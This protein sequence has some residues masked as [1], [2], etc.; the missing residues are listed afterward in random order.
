MGRAQN[1]KGDA[2]EL[3]VRA[4]AEPA[5]DQIGSSLDA[6]YE[7]AADS[8]P[9][10]LML[11]DEGLVP[12]SQRISRDNWVLFIRQMF[13]FFPFCGSFENYIFTIK[14]VFG[15]DAFIW[16]DVPEAGK[17]EI[18]VSGTDSLFDAIVREYSGGAYTEFTLVD[19]DDDIIQFSTTAGIDN[20]YELKLLFSEM[21]PVGI[22]STITLDFFVPYLLIGDEGSNEFEITDHLG[23]NILLFEV[24]S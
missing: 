12:F 8:L 5:L 23:N 9:F 2:T 21:T 7:E 13:S 22:F 11:Y 4:C 10:L 17:L 1:F 16:F 20:E 18:S 14:S 6:M 15:P 3:K 19:S 24:G